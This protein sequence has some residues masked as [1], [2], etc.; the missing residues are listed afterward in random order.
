MKTDSIKTR[1]LYRHAEHPFAQYVR[2]L[3]K[4]KRGTR[5][6]SQAEA[7]AAFS[8]IL[9]NAVLDEQLGAFMMLLRV[10]EESV[11][12]LVGFVK[13]TKHHISTRFR[14][15]Q[16][17]LDWPSYAGKRKH[18][19]WYLL[20]ALTLARHGTRVLM[21]GAA[22]HTLNRIYSEDLLREMGHRIAHTDISQTDDSISTALDT[23]HFCY[24]PMTVMQ[25]QLQRII[26]MRNVFGLRSP[27]HTL[28]RLINPFDAPH[29]LQSIFHPAYQPSHV[30][31]AYK[32]GY[33]NT[34]VIKG[35]G[36]EFERNPDARSKVMGLRTVDGHASPYTLK[37]PMLNPTKSPIE[38]D[39]T[40]ARLLAVWESK[41][42]PTYAI[43]AITET[44][45]LALMSLKKAHSYQQAKTTATD[46]WHARHD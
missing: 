7:F 44:L 29:S 19:A 31:A 8:M 36:G 26:D 41:E 16:V 23:H 43:Q 21:H 42:T 20:A 25:P 24:L 11:D 34:V 39:L 38:D 37:L 12:E 9:D 13:A 30:M 28:A 45:A 22:G 4:G 2:I 6:L 5:N 10:K 35:D 17:D 1:N 33:Q 40:V 27:V 18:H 3:G 14:P 46:M 15:Q 32:L